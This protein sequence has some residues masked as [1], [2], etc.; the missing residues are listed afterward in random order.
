MAESGFTIKVKTEQLISA[1]GDVEGKI[2][3]LE[4]AFAEIERTV[5]GSRRYWEGDG[6]SAYQQAYRKKADTIRAALQR[7]RNSAVNLQQI[8]GV[9]DQSERK[10]TAIN[11][12]L[13]SNWID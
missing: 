3:C 4:Q 2:R 5:N 11:S 13:S 1:A 7:F 6:A 8:A 10:V 12:A 9:Y